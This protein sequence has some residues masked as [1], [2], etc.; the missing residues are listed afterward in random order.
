MELLMPR[1]K[2]RS[3]RA[4]IWLWSALASLAIWSPHESNAA[5]AREYAIKAAFLF[6]FSQFVEWPESAFA[7]AEAPFVMG[8]LGPNPFGAALDA[9]VEGQ[10]VGGRPIEVRYLTDLRGLPDCHLL[11]VTRAAAA[12]TPEVAALAVQYNILTVGD[13]PTF[14]RRGGMVGFVMD[15]NRVRFEVNLG[16][17]RRAGLNMSSRLLRLAAVVNAENT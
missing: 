15:R 17:I 5:E 14:A 2:Q 1:R 10:H 4:R 8:I 7:D 3:L 9:I 6:N 16:E 11:F 13:V 12:L